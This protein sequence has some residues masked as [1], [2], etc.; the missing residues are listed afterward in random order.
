MIKFAN[1][2]NL[3]G[4]CLFSQ[5]VRTINILIVMRR[6]AQFKFR[7]FYVISAY[8]EDIYGRYCFQKSQ[9]T[10]I[11]STHNNVPLYK[12]KKIKRSARPPFLVLADF[13]FCLPPDKPRDITFIPSVLRRLQRWRVSWIRFTLLFLY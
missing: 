2:S 9:W 5:N 4:V 10:V 3:G 8:C 6:N 13:I 11:T 1:T 7:H 12:G